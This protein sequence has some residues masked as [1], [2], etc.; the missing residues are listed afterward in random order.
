MAPTRPP[1]RA[2]TRNVKNRRIRHLR[3]PWIIAHILA[4]TNCTE[5][6]SEDQRAAR[7]A[8]RRGLRRDSG[9]STGFCWG[10]RKGLHLYPLVRHLGAFGV[11]IGCPSAPCGIF[12]RVAGPACPRPSTADAPFGDKPGFPIREEA[13]RWASGRSRAEDTWRGAADRADARSHL[14][15]PGPVSVVHPTRGHPVE[16]PRRRA[17]TSP[18][19]VPGCP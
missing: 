18:R 1:Q 4:A 16:S 11:N 17:G 3:W 10:Q 2:P 5:W 13:W 15:G 12:S 9:S 19:I 14:P 8:R 6:N 7:R